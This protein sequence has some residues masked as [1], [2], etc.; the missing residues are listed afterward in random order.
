MHITVCIPTRNRGLSIARTLRSLAASRYED[1]DVVVVDQSETDA[2]AQAVQEATAGDARFTYLHSQTVGAAAARNIAIAQAEGPII[3]FT[4][5]DCEVSPEWLAAL[6][7]AFSQY[8]KVGEVCGPVQAASHDAAAGFIPTYEIGR[9]AL[10]SS[11]WAMWRAGGIGANMAFRL[12]TLRKAG[13]FDEILGPGAA[14]YSCE[15]G[16]MTYRVLKAGY[17]VFNTPD[18]AVIHSGFR[19]FAEG[20]QF[21]RQTSLGVGAAYMKHLR[22]GDLGILPTMLYIGLI[23][24]I[25]WKNLLLLRKRT[26]L[27]RLLYYIRGILASFHFSIDRST[28]LYRPRE[29]RASAA[30]RPSDSLASLSE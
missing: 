22:L 7:A 13:P 14:L 17:Q 6:V 15:E 5:D 16:D 4:D 9:R 20:K 10:I 8:P 27:G 21:I 23:W 25:S 24:C 18:A 1:F 19:S 11:R 12:E 3:A 26:G 30:A 2:T 28:L 29:E